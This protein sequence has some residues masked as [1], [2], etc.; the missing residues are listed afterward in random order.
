MNMDL[1]TLKNRCGR[2]FF[3]GV[4]GLIVL[5]APLQAQAAVKEVATEAIGFGLSRDAAVN[6]AIENA[7][8]KA[9]GISLS[10][11]VDSYISTNDLTVNGQSKYKFTDSFVKSIK[12]AVNTPI[13]N[14]VLGYDVVDQLVQD[15]GQWQVKISLRYAKYFQQAPANNRRSMIVVSVDSNT[16]ELRDRI[17]EGIVN[18]RRFNILNRSSDDAFAN[19]VAFLKS[20]NVQTQE[21]AR[22][23]QAKGADYILAISAKKNYE[24]KSLVIEMS[25]E[26]IK[27]YEFSYDVNAKVIDFS[28]Q[29]IK[30]SIIQDFKIKARSK[31]EMIEKLDSELS[32]VASLVYTSMTNSIYPPRLSNISSNGQRAILNRGIGAIMED[33]LVSAYAVGKLIVDPQ[34][35]ASLGYEEN[36]VGYGFVVESKPKYSVIQM[37]DGA[38]LSP[39]LQYIVRWKER[40]LLKTSKGIDVQSK[41]YKAK[42][43]T[44]IFLQN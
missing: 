42:K 5:V 43:N 7:I 29:E 39:G 25:G 18:G 44:S 13:A 23:A 3:C 16:D 38:Q 19:E 8:G 15:D 30:W 26:V 11:S 10:S 20:G 40:T 14:P 1:I 27:S 36:L 32:R 34:S 9:F 35:G 24:E 4:A 12:T 17:E 2:F 33:Q 31:P 28:T 22:L 41:I 6:E 37:Q 21:L